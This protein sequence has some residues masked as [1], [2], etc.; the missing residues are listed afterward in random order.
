MT[1]TAGERKSKKKSARARSKSAR[2]LCDANRVPAPNRLLRQSCLFLRPCFHSFC[3]SFCFFSRRSRVLR[4]PK[5]K[6]RFL[7]FCFLQL[8]KRDVRLRVATV[9][10][11]GTSN[12]KRNVIDMDSFL[13]EL[14]HLRAHA[15]ARVVL[16]H[17]HH[18]QRRPLSLLALNISKIY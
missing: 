12:K 8:M 3:L 17:H 2:V 11:S 5:S 14:L 10:P 13:N 16:S 9:L 1:P 7:V 6:T 4:V 15:R 18:H